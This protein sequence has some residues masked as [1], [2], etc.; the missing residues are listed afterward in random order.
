MSGNR[1]HAV[2]IIERGFCAVA[3]MCIDIY[4]KNPFKSVQ[5][6]EHAQR[7]VIDVAEALGLRLGC[8]MATPIP[9]Q[10]HVAHALCQAVTGMQ[11]SCMAEIRCGLES[12]C[13]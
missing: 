13:C 4:D 10:G 5:K 8:V 12:R 3:V 1:Q 7:H 2:C 11:S 9:V 6:P